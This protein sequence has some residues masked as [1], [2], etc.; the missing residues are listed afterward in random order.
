VLSRKLSVIRR[1]EQA[2]ESRF[3]GVPSGLGALNAAVVEFS[4]LAASGRR[5]AI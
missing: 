3:C 5:W 4:W 2:S 1:P